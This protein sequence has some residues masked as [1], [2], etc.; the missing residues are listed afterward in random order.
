MQEEVEEEA[1]VLL[2]PFGDEGGFMGV[3]EEVLCLLALT[4]C[5]VIGRRLFTELAENIS[6]VIVKAKIIK[7]GTETLAIQ[8]WLFNFY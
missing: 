2:P 7:T 1:R 3:D 5:I 6:N 4:S 8:K